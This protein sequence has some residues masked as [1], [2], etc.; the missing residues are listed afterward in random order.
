VTLVDTSVWIEHLRRGEATLAGLLSSA[1]V[2]SH[3]FVI[4]E[5]AMGSLKNR[6]EILGLLDN[7]PVAPVASHDEVLTLVERY[8]LAGLGLGWIDAHLLASARLASTRLWT[9]DRRLAESA[10][11]LGVRFDV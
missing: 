4:G 10:R 7:L 5:L 11:A 8:R 3:P 1:M 6:R 2:M 9:F